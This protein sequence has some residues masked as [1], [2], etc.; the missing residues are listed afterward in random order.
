MPLYF[1]TKW[2]CL[3]LKERGGKNT[4]NYNA[5]AFLILVND[6]SIH[7]INK[8]KKSQSYQPKQP[9]QHRSSYWT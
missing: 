7:Q 8:I 1:A 2:R 5:N 6:S 9:Y 4:K 3:T